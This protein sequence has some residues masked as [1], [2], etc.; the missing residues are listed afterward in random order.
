MTS[1]RKYT[2]TI[3]VDGTPVERTVYAL[4]GREAPVAAM[5]RKV[6]RNSGLVLGRTVS[7]EMEQS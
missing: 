3:L 5:A 4:P 2:V 6:L 7:V 1:R